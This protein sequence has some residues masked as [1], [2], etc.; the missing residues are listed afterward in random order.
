M[1]PQITWSHPSVQPTAG[2]VWST[3][4]PYGE[5]ARR[6]REI[7]LDALENG[8]SG[9]AVRPLRARRTRSASRSVPREDLDDARLV[10]APGEQPRIEFNPHRRPARVRFSVAHELGHLLFERPRGADAL[11]H[12]EPHRA[13]APRRLAARGAVQRRGRR[14][15]DAGRSVPV[16]RKP[17]ICHS[18][19]SSICASS[20]VSRPR[21]CCDA[22]SNSPSAPSASSRLPGLT[23]R[24]L[25]PRLR[26]AV[27]AGV[28]KRSIRLRTGA[29]VP[30]E[31]VLSKC[32]AV[33]YSVDNSERWP[34]VLGNPYGCRRSGSRHT[35]GDS[36]P[37]V[38]GL[39][40]P[41]KDSGGGT[42]QKA[43]CATSEA[44][45]R[46]PGGMARRSSRTLST[47]VREAGRP[48]LRARLGCR[49]PRPATNTQS[50]RRA[51]ATSAGHVAY[52]PG[53]RRL[54]VASIVAQGGYGQLRARVC[55]Y[56]R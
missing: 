44:T 6:A 48:G 28:D 43:V 25:P 49:F 4:I 37:R 41:Q 51:A 24:R 33:G 2:G 21:R 5:I 3:S 22:W 31:T 27:R 11:P 45:R 15:P 40:T 38:V 10:S 56:R 50:G 26:G 29:S 20:S 36:F 7:V 13:R 35:P 1:S 8:W 32:T 52:R 14:D 42:R 39:L 18:R 54:W 46:N 53:R 23:G 47:T 30:G 17:T 55:D 9:P 19:T 16:P 12:R 34:G